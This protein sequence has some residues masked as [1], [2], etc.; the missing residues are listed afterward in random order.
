MDLN[1]QPMNQSCAVSG[2]AFEDGQRV[3]SYL[4]APPAAPELLRFDVL[5]EKAAG[6]QPQGPVVC[7]WVHQYKARRSGESG[8]RA[9][10]LTTENLFLTLADPLTEPTEENVRLLLF[11]A[12]MLERKRILRQRGRTADGNRIRYEH[13]RSKQIFELPATELTP[14]FFV[15]V[16]EQLSVLVGVPKKQAKEAA[17]AAQAQAQAQAPADQPSPQTPSTPSE[18]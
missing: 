2:L 18:V 14:E 12:L 7:R 5:E 16:Q 3:A 4:V 11:L 10:K 17:A 13:A 1:I 9:L 6:F 8:D 15:Q